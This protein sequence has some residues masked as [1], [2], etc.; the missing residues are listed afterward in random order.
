MIKQ[1]NQ[2]GEV[3]MV[4]TQEKTWKLEEYGETKYDTVV[5]MTPTINRVPEA[6]KKNALLNF[7]N[8]GKN[9]IIIADKTLPEA[10]TEFLMDSGIEF[11]N[12]ANFIVDHFNHEEEDG[13]HQLITSTAM[14]RDVIRKDVGKIMYKGVA[15]TNANKS[16]LVVP[17]LTGSKTSYVLAEDEQEAP[18]AI[19]EEAMLVAGVQ[20]RNGARITVIGS[21]DMVSDSFY[22]KQATGNNAFGQ[23]LFLWA[24]GQRGILRHR[25]VK[26]HVVGETTEKYMYTI[27]ENIT[28]SVIV[29]EYDQTKGGWI[30]Y[31]AN[32]LQLE[33]IMLDPYVR[34]SLNHIDAGRYES[35][36]QVPD[37]YG[38]FKF[39]VDYRRA[40]YSYLIFNNKQT[41]RPYRM[42]QYDR[43]IPAAYPYYVSMF[44][45][46]IGF[47]IF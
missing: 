40:G 16:P 35:T 44:S 6:L 36:F 39:K 47:F 4:T 22:D 8:E 15:M 34:T 12:G 23:E 26:H 27:N 45:A 30:P 5:L 46:F 37:T 14:N 41:V 28:Y 29:E 10:Y 33:F 32:D 9:I 17:I 2:I 3:N 42:D 25:Q 11:E 31:V 21:M 38:V 19:G 43:F 18:V 7:F 24:T 13:L 20:G 1:L